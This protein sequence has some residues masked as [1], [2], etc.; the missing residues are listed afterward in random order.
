[1]MPEILLSSLFFLPTNYS[2]I[3]GMNP[4]RSGKGGQEKKCITVIH[5][6]ETHFFLAQ[7]LLRLYNIKDFSLFF[8]WCVLFMIFWV[9]GVFFF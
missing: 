3:F 5:T 6:H 9:T 4:D 8:F 7:L 1:M 2:S